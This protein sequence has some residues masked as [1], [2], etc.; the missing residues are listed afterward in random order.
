MERAYTYDK[1][2]TVYDPA[3]SSGTTVAI[4]CLIVSLL[5]EVVISRYKLVSYSLKAMWLL[6]IISAIITI[7]GESLYL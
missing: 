7:C 2:N 1:L 4:S 5:A 3:F 6:S